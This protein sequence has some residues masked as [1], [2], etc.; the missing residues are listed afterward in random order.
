MQIIVN[1][2]SLLTPL[3]GVGQYVRHLFSALERL[4]GVDIHMYH[5]LRF[6]EG[7]R[8]PSPRVSRTLGDLCRIARRIVPRPRALR[9]M[10]QERAFARQAR[11]FGADCLYHEPG[12]P[13]LPHDGP[14]VLTIHDLSCFDHPET[15][16]RERVDLMQREMP[17]AI[18]RASRILVISEATGQA[19]RHWFDVRE[20][21]IHITRLAA[22]ARFHPRPRPQLETP[23]ATLGLCPGAYLLCVGTLEPRKNLPLLFAAYS[24]LPGTLRRRFPLVVAGM[25]GWG[26]NTLPKH[27]AP[28]ARTGEIRFPGYVHDDLLPLLYA[29][30]AAFAYPSRYEGFGLPPLE[31]MASGTPVITANRTS[32]PEVVGEAGLMVDPDDVDGLR[33]GLRQLLECPDTAARFS[34]LGLERAATFNWQRCALETLAAYRQI[35]PPGETARNAP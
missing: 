18:A 32:L 12:F 19:L 23:L 7:V 15:H 25:P 26:G 21:P 28:L 3:T 4:P 5:G 14:L 27:C 10:I 16:P 13:P 2:T 29:G 33:Q 22:D 20:T 9:Q 31:A 34:R 6:S 17:T 8:L 11:K 35:L 30:A 1:G 24:G